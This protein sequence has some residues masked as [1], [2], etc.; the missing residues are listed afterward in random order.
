MTETT[1]QTQVHICPKCRNI[2]PV[3]KGYP[4]WCDRC[5]WNILPEE[6]ISK[7]TKLSGWVDRLSLRV[8]SGMYQ[9]V[10]KNPGLPPRWS[11]SLALS[12]VLSVLILLVTL[13]L[14]AA[15]LFSIYVGFYFLPALLIGA[16]FLLFAWLLRPRFGKT[17]KSP[18]MPAEYP[19][20]YGLV[21]RVCQQ[22]NA[23]VDGICLHEGMA[24]GVSI[25]GMRQKKMLWIGLPYWEILSKEERIAALAQALTVQSLDRFQAFLIGAGL[26]TLKHW[27]GLFNVN[28]AFLA[29]IVLWI[30][31][32]PI[33]LIEFS[34]H[35]LICRDVQRSIFLADLAAARMAGT[36]PAIRMLKKRGYWRIISFAMHRYKRQEADPGKVFDEIQ[37]AVAET[38][39]REFLRQEHIARMVAPRIDSPTPPEWMRIDLLE[40]QYYG[41]PVLTIS[42]QEMH[43]IEAELE[44]MK[45]VV[46]SWLIFS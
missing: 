35:L 9:E 33:A 34:M 17:P 12:A 45:A 2:L 40:D 23:R 7:P 29:M 30:L 16:A 44:P 18:L 19:Q 42:D 20:L 32:A 10:R 27:R 37:K 43:Q 36:L 3:I 39:Q 38:P 1:A 46:G 5:H 6:W 15:G 14:T 13:V 21:D 11:L 22:V 28:G 8:L 31:L 41:K 4:T 24:I 26:D 25:S